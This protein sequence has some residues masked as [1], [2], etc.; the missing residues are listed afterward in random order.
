[1][2]VCDFESVWKAQCKQQ[3]ARRH[4][5]YVIYYTRRVVYSLPIYKERVCEAVCTIRVARPTTCGGDAT[6]SR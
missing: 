4:T 5:R 6:D 2:T 3:H 1:M